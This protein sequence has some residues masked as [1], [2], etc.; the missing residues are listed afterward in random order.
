MQPRFREAF[1]R[2]V[3]TALETVGFG[4]LAHPIQR[5]QHPRE[6]MEFPWKAVQPAA[7]VRR[8]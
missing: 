4:D 6:Q 5:A 1:V 7:C 3:Q 8:T 2:P